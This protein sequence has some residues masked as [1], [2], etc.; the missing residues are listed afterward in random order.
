MEKRHLRRN[1][2]NYLLQED[3]IFYVENLPDEMPSRRRA[4]MSIIAR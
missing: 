4:V 3:I 2:V 1:P